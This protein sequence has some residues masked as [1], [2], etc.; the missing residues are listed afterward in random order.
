M[1]LLINLMCSFWISLLNKLAFWLC[2]TISK[3]ILS[4][5]NLEM[6]LVHQISILEIVRVYSIYSGT[7]KLHATFLCTALWSL[8]G[9]LFLLDFLLSPP[10]WECFVFAVGHLLHP[11]P[12]ILCALLHKTSSTWLVY[13]LSQIRKAHMV[14]SCTVVCRTPHLLQNE[15]PGEAILCLVDVFEILTY[16]IL[17]TIVLFNCTHY[18]LCI[19]T[20]YYRKRV[21][22]LTK[23]VCNSLSSQDSSWLKRWKC[24]CRKEKSIIRCFI[25][26][27]RQQ[28]D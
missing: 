6:F 24:T 7:Q 22:R 12:S 14:L 21:V 19:N 9:S 26:F 13:L 17:P 2:I 10:L 20:V 27:S 16:C 15:W 8:D 28:L 4:S 1:S 18:V 25:C 23:H 3:K 11:P 5:K